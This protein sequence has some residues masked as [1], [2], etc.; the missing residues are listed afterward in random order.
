MHPWPPA[1]ARGY[2]I[3]FAPYYRVSMNP[4]EELA[5]L[6]AMKRDL[7]ESLKELEARM[8]KLKDMITKE[9]TE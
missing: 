9:K 5:M 2:W 4:Q 3:S 8:N 7:D 1:W 6:N